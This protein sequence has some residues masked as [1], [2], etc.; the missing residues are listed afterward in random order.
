MSVLKELTEILK[1]VDAINERYRTLK[2][3]LTQD[4]SEILRDL[5]VVYKDLTDHKIEAHK[6]WLDAYNSASGA[7][8]K[9][10]READNEVQ[11]NTIIR[12]IMRAVDNQMNAVRSTLSSSKNG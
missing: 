1:E 2:L 8:A 5:S 7:N 4:Q 3:S 6:S 9:K 12:Y 11:E 10:E